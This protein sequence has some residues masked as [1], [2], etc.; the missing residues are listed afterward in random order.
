MDRR[1]PND[2]Q[3]NGSTAHRGWSARRWN[4][5]IA[6]IGGGRS[7]L[8]LAERLQHAGTDYTLLEARDRLGGRI[9]SRVIDGAAFDLGPAWFWPI[10]PRM[11][12]LVSRLGLDVFDQFSEGAI[13]AED[14]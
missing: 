6:I 7:G 2:G 9:L 12:A 1:K 3:R 11:A 13:V 4:T 10:Q 8:A 5:D 14:R